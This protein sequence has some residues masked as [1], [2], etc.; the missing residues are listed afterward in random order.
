MAES[1][2]GGSYAPIEKS[3]FT[4]ANG[5]SADFIAHTR[6]VAAN[7]GVTKQTDLVTTTT[8]VQPITAAQVNTTPADA[9]DADSFSV[10][11][12]RDGDSNGNFY[13]FDL[14]GD[15]GDDALASMSLVIPATSL[16]GKTQTDIV[17]SYSRF[18]LQGVSEAEQEKYQVVETFTGYYAFFYGK[19]PPI[20]RYS[21]LLLTD[22]VYRWNNDFKFVYENYFRGTSAV[23]FGAEVI[24]VYDGRQITGFPL[25]LTMQQDAINDK[26]IPFS[27][28]V[29]VVS[30][31]TLKFSDDIAAFL[32]A[33]SQ[34]LAAIRA[35]M[36]AYI[37]KLT[38]ATSATA[39]AADN[40]TNGQLPASSA[41]LP[42]VLAGGGN[43]IS[44]ISSSG[45]GSLFA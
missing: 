45:A 6:A 27:M 39:S 14:N 20:Y 31:N 21:G 44:Q 8:Q 15:P 34:Q 17:S 41:N 35:N 22:Q 5:Y 30:H 16:N 4:A 11:E 33:K 1:F 40:V 28:D 7:D 19:R 43:P 24:I 36:A 10:D 25:G 32:Q 12:W 29:L 38:G 9:P 26:G 18:F 3:P 2:T 13:T 23:E 37:A 42:G